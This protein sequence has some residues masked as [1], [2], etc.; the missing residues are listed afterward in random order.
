MKNSTKLKIWGFTQLVVGVILIILSGTVFKEDDGFSD[1]F[2]KPN[3]FLFS[4]GSMFSVFSLLI[5]A[6]G[7]NPQLAKFNAKL[8]SEVIDHAG[9][10]IKEVMS[11]SANT[12]IPA[13]TPSLKEAVSVIGSNESKL[14]KSDQLIEA[15][16]LLDEQLISDDEYQKMRSSILGI[17]K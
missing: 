7:F 16:K 10:E 9:E 6:A 4:L 3:F 17:N 2:W 14:S 5:I 13:I 15:K 1:F 11:K 12:V 8:Q